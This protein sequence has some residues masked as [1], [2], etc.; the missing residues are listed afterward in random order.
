MG[1]QGEE[2]GYLDPRGQHAQVAGCC[3]LVIGNDAAGRLPVNLAPREAHINDQHFNVDTGA[4]ACIIQDKRCITRPDL[5]CK[6]KI[7]IK[8]GGGTTYAE[9][10]G[11]ATF[12]VLDEGGKLIELTR[13][14]VYAPTLGTTYSHQRPNGTCMAG[15]PNSTTACARPYSAEAASRPGATA[16]R[17]SSHT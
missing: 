17:T 5:H 1:G 11:P 3:A 13:I 15:A 10:V 14:V 12:Y 8:T 9:S 7:A 6:Q 2:R 16:A 4:T